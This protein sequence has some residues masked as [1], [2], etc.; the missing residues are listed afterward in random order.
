MRHHCAE[1]LH[2]LTTRYQQ[3]GEVLH[4]NRVHQ[5]RL[6][7]NIHP[8]EHYARKSGLKLLKPGFVFAAGA[9]PV[10]AQASD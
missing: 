10:C 7:F 3:S 1:K 2:L 5:L 4:L 9:A 6:V 8:Y